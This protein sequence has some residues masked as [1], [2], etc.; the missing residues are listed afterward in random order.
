MHIVQVTTTKSSASLPSHPQE[1]RLMEFAATT[2]LTPVEWLN[3]QFASRGAD[4]Q[5]EG[6]SAKLLSNL[7]LQMYKEQQGL[8][9]ICNHLPR[10]HSSLSRDIPQ[11]RTR[12]DYLIQ[13]VSAVESLLTDSGQSN[14]AVQKMR[15]TETVKRR[16]EQTYRS[17]ENQDNWE[18]LLSNFKDVIAGGDFDVLHARMVALK[19]CLA[20]L[21]DSLDSNERHGQLE[22]IKNSTESALIPRLISALASNVPWT[23]E[24]RRQSVPSDG[25][26]QKILQVFGVMERMETAKRVL[27]ETR[28]RQFV[29]RWEKQSEQLLEETSELLFD[30]VVSNFYEDLLTAWHL[31]MPVFMAAFGNSAAQ[32]LLEMYTRV[33]TKV[34]PKIQTQLQNTRENIATSEAAQEYLGSLLQLKRSREAFAFAIEKEYHK[35]STQQ[36]TV[37]D[38]VTTLKEPL[39]NAMGHYV[40]VEELVLQSEMSKTVLAVADTA[41][42]LQGLTAASMRIGSV[43]FAAVARCQQFADGSTVTANLLSDLGRALDASVDGYVSRVAVFAQD[44]LTNSGLSSSERKTEFPDKGLD[45]W[46]DLLKVL[47]HYGT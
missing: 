38:F 46:N 31:Q 42:S 6:Y 8:D 34:N 32:A 19:K 21:T 18:A 44:L 9:D 36:Q 26:L 5:P 3:Q 7:N 47:L 23:A 27:K 35:H 24:T 2:G 39:D 20:S 17:L 12:F 13:D 40:E 41:K 25:P 14:L 11:I 15:A 16:M 43:L 33:I 22:E 30:E 29:N 28:L 45:S 10:V 1:T 37:T 4:E